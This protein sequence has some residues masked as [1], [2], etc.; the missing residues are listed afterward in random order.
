MTALENNTEQPNE[1]YANQT[2]L[3][4]SLIQE[5]EGKVAGLAAQKRSAF[6]QWSEHK[7]REQHPNLVP[8]NLF[9]I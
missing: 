8:K 1:T 7:S 4:A 9:K 2:A 3:Y 5:I 6:K